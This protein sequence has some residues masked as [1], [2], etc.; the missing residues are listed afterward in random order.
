MSLCVIDLLAS[1]ILGR[2]AATAALLRD[3]RHDLAPMVATPAEGRLLSSYTLSIIVQ[4]IVGRLYTDK[5][6]SADTAN[7]LLGGLNRWSEQLTGSLRTPS[8]SGDSGT[9]QEHS[10]GNLHVACSYHFAVILVTR[11]FLISTLSLRLARLH[12]SHSTGEVDTTLEED[13]ASSRLATAC[14][15]SAIYM[16]QAC[17]EVHQ[18]DL[19]LRNMGILKYVLSSWYTSQLKSSQIFSGPS[20][21]QPHWYWAFQCSLTVTSIPKP[22]LHS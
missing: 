5:T 6:A 9:V 17:A 4:E 3:G 11:P 15:D 22:T 21:L 13:P 14:M 8:Q 2:P 18:S 19:L 7:T 20:C 12:Q 10:I 16:L 1:S